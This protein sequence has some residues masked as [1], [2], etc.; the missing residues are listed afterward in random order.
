MAK[1]K[2]KMSPLPLE[3][4]SVLA[5]M[6]APFKFRQLDNPWFVAWDRHHF[7]TDSPSFKGKVCLITSREPG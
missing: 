5:K 1:N 2:I 6:R 4:Q 3:I 7:P